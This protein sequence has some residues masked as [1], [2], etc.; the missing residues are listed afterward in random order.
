MQVDEGFSCGRVSAIC[1][2]VGICVYAGFMYKDHEVGFDS[3]KTMFFWGFFVGVA[4][5]ILALVSG[6]LFF[7][8]GCC[9]RNHT[10][11]HTAQTGYV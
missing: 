3:D 1:G 10:G 11:Y 9:G 5:V 6:I 4:G 7:C 8:Q 2:G